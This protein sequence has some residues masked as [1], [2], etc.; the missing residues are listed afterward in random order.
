MRIII[1]TKQRQRYVHYKKT[2]LM[3]IHH[4]SDGASVDLV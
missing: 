4:Y 1:Y 2:I 3:F